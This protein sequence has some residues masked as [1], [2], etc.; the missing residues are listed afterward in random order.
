MTEE[1]NKDAFGDAEEK[2]ETLTDTLSEDTKLK[3]EAGEPEE[4]LNSDKP[5]LKKGQSM[6][7]GEIVYKNVSASKL[8]AIFTKLDMLEAVSDKGRLQSYKSKNKDEQ[9]LT[10]RVSKVEDHYVVAYKTFKDIVE[11]NPLTGVWL[12]DQRTQLFFHDT[13]E[14]DES[15]IIST[16]IIGELTKELC[17]VTGDSTDKVTGVRTLTV[18]TEAGKEFKINA[19]FINN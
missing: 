16:K 7:N 4:G 5:K 15:V 6:V 19:T 17:T 1:K 10:V 2:D 8:D 18:K 12:Q 9:Y 3:V 11:K 13:E 14:G